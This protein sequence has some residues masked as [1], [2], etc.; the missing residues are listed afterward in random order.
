MSTFNRPN[1]IRCV[2]VWRIQILARWQ[3]FGHFTKGKE[4]VE[5]GDGGGGGINNKN[6]K[7][8]LGTRPQS[9]QVKDSK[10]TQGRGTVSGDPARHWFSLSRPRAIHKVHP[11]HRVSEIKHLLSRL[12][13]NLAGTYNTTV[14]API[15]AGIVCHTHST[16]LSTCA[17]S[18]SDYLHTR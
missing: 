1:H 3:Q 15:D 13:I 7:Q 2:S 16:R 11:V 8:K 14:D 17:K 12:I 9:L 18:Q 10:Q 6:K 5:G 4:R